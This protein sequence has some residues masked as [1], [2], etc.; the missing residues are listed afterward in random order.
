[1][2]SEIEASRVGARLR[3]VDTEGLSVM[4][5]WA[6]G[7]FAGDLVAAAI[8]KSG[9]AARAKNRKVVIPGVAAVIS[10][11]LEEELG[12]EWT[13]LVGPREASHITPFLRQMAGG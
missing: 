2:S 5:A 10:G 4:T 11:E 1:V 3:V 13:V 9:I 7:K 8:K 12:S 6:A